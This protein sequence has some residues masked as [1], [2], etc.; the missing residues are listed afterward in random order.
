MTLIDRGS[1]KALRYLGAERVVVVIGDLP[2][3]ELMRVARSLER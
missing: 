1:E 2:P 3:E